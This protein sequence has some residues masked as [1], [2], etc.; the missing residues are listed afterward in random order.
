[1]TN[2]NNLTSLRDVLCIDNSLYM[3]YSAFICWI[4]EK[5]SER[6]VKNALNQ[7]TIDAA[8]YE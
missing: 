3:A 6:M 5:L 1:M 7:Y 4:N 8:L 2:D